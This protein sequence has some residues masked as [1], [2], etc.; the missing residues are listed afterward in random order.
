MHAH[1][2]YQDFSFLVLN[3]FVRSLQLCHYGHFGQQIA[4]LD[5]SSRTLS[6]VIRNHGKSKLKG[7]WTSGFTSSSPTEAV[8]WIRDN[9]TYGNLGGAFLVEDITTPT[10]MWVVPNKS[11][12]DFKRSQFQMLT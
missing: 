12:R 11:S 4:S 1:I 3:Q 2:L 5:N 9:G 10:G 7:D 8:T 6:A